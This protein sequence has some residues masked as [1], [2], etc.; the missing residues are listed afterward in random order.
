MRIET[1]VMWWGFIDFKDRITV[2]RFFSPQIIRQ[3]EHDKNI[4]GIFDP[5]LAEDREE[6]M[7]MVLN[8][9]RIQ[10]EQDKSH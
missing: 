2:K 5:F 4:K 7:E 3:A 10:L 1:G 8:R 9:Y 6:A